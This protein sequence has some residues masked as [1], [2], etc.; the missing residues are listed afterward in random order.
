MF[1][2]FMNRFTKLFRVNLG[3][4]VAA[5]VFQN[6]R[7]QYQNISSLLC[8]QKKSQH[9]Q[10]RDS[11]L[12]ISVSVLLHSSCIELEIDYERLEKHYIVANTRS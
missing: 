10:K 2:E 1:L 8:S 4:I 12:Q 7:L 9:V 3:V 5:D 6:I 11:L